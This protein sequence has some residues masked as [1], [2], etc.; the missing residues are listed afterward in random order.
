MTNLRSIETF[1]GQG[2]ISV[3]SNVSDGIAN[4]IHRIADTSKGKNASFSEIDN[5]L[6]LSQQINP[7]S[8]LGRP[9]STICC[10]RELTKG[11]S[12]LNNGSDIVSDN[13]D[14]DENASSDYSDLPNGDS[15]SCPEHGSNDDSGSTSSDGPQAST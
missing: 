7:H 12:T 10:Q 14:S 5:N 1:K 2:E 13:N 9:S 11:R 15:F 6:R 4:R 8:C 3:F